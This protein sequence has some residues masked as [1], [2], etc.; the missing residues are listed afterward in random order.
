MRTYFAEMRKAF[1]KSASAGNII[2]GPNTKLRLH[3]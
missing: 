2:T 3:R 1:G